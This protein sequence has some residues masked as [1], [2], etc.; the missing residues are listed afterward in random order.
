MLADRRTASVP[1]RIILLI[2]SIIT[3]NDIRAEG[4]PWGTKWENIELVKLI[5]PI[6]INESQRGRARV[7][8]VIIWLV[9]VKMN[10]NNPI[11]L[12]S[13]IKINKL[14]NIMGAP[15]NRSRLVRILISW[16]SRNLI[17]L[18]IK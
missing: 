9:A 14:K 1:G 2:V 7:N 15:L 5:H 18:K 12:F 4:V 13:R 8:V 11:K 10:G 16:N 17:F 6:S 3:M